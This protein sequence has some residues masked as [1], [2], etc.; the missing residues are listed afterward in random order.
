[1]SHLTHA[2]R[3]VPVVSLSLTLVDVVVGQADTAQPLIVPTK[4]PLPAAYL[5]RGLDEPAPGVCNSN[6]YPYLGNFLSSPFG[7]AAVRVIFLLGAG[8]AH[9]LHSWGSHQRGREP[10]LAQSLPS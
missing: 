3:S 2:W 6:R 9:L 5:R 10:P 7:F 8:I 1:V 4:L